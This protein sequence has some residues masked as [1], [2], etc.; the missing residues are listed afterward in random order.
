MKYMIL[1]TYTCLNEAFMFKKS[2]NI[3]W[4]VIY[5]ENSVLRTGYLKVIKWINY[6]F[7][8]IQLKWLVSNNSFNKFFFVNN[9]IFIIIIILLWNMVIKNVM[10]FF[11]LFYKI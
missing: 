1:A 6:E 4:S 11:F 3:Q 5:C 7:K 2:K 10:F 9:I 8:K